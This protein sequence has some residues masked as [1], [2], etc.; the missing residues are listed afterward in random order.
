MAKKDGT[1]MPLVLLITMTVGLTIGTP[2]IMFT[3]LVMKIH[4]WKLFKYTY[5][6]QY[7]FMYDFIFNGIV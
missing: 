3:W 7:T 4:V 6:Y 1:E 5:T 2:I